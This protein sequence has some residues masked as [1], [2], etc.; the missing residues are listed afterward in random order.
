MNALAAIRRRASDDKRN[1]RGLRGGNRHVSRC[2]VRIAPRGNVTAGHIDRDQPLAGR[3]PWLH[4][5][6]EFADRFTLGLRE[7]A[8]SLRREFDVMLHGSRDIANPPLD[9]FRCHHDRPRPVIE[10]RRVIAHRLLA[11]A[12]NFCEH[13][14]GDR[15]GGC[16]FGFRRL[17][18]SLQVLD[19][20][21]RPPIMLCRTLA[22]S[23]RWCRYQS[24]GAE[25]GLQVGF[26]NVNS[27]S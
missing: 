20:H 3:E 9:L 4:L 21:G 27:P 6:G 13:L 23:G 12:R 8:Y 25:S 2:D 10:L 22:R 26:A 14:L 1:P 7:A 17:R 24:P 16:G 18:G 15:T 5:D 11:V 19:G